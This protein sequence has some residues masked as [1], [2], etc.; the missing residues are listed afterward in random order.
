MTKQKD[1]Q[2]IDIE[3]SAEIMQAYI[4]KFGKE[5]YVIG[6]FW[7]DRERFNQNLLD[8]IKSGVPYNEYEFLDDD[9]KKAFDEGN[10]LF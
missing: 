3:R 9:E 4:R 2:S 10:L 5:P 6:M 1:S 8:A 7:S